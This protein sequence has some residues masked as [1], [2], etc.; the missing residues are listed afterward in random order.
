M[1]FIDNQP[2]NL[3]E[4][5][6]GIRNQLY[7][8]AL[9]WYFIEG[10]AQN[11]AL[12][13]PDAASIMLLI[14]VR[15]VSWCACRQTTKLKCVRDQGKKRKRTEFKRGRIYYYTWYKKMEIAEQVDE[16]HYL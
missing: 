14:E 3:F 13:R 15:Q 6:K 5:G 12:A 11:E 16:R 1:E 9:R 7:S 8:N 4:A 10:A 2:T